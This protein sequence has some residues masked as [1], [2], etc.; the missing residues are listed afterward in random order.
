MS[1]LRLVV[2]GAAIAAAVW[3]SGGPGSDWVDIP[4]GQQ[5]EPA[6]SDYDPDVDLDRFS[7]DGFNS[8]G[9]VGMNDDVDDGSDGFTGL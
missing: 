6:G 9:R 4:V 3:L 2:A 5:T 8:S 1:S 7:P